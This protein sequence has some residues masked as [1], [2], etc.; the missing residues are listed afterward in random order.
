MAQTKQEQ[1]GEKRA[2]SLSKAGWSYNYN[3]INHY[4]PLGL[5]GYIIYNVDLLHLF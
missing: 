3:I 5:M 1:Q 4:D 2:W